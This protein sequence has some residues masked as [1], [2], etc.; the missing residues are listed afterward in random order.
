[1]PETLEQKCARYE[2]AVRAIKD[3]TL[4]PVDFGDY[5]QCVCEDVLDGQEAEC[6]NCGTC[7]HEGPCVG[8]GDKTE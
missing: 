5:V 8:E 7:V 3:C 4:G 6:W 1:M 2:R